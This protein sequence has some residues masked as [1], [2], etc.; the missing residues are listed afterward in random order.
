M[1][2]RPQTVTIST[3]FFGNFRS[4]FVFFLFLPLDSSTLFA[5][6]RKEQNP[7]ERE[8]EI[9]K[10]KC[11]LSSRCVM[12]WRLRSFR[13]R[14]ATNPPTTTTTTK[15]SITSKVNL[16]DFLEIVAF[17]FLLFYRFVFTM[18]KRHTG[19]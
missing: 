14:S 12:L 7:T 19:N 9:E 15:V 1:T 18:L 2:K 4:L 13:R 11:F 17:S 8:N 10:G 3:E 5:S 6:T 16:M